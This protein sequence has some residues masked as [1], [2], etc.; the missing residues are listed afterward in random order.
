MEGN[1]EEA[2]QKESISSTC[3]S[4][5]FFV[6]VRLIIMER[7]ETYPLKMET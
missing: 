7:G 1:T 6:D 2:C 5:I 3:S 4:D